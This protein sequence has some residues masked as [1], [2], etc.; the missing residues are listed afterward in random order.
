MRDRIE[1][2]LAGYEAGTITRA[3]FVDQLAALAGG[4]VDRSD[5]GA[6]FQTLGLNHVALS[7]SDVDAMAQFMGAHLGTTVIHSNENA[8]F[9]ACGANHFIG[10]FRTDPL[11]LNHVCFSVEGYDPDDAAV[12]L[13]RAGFSPHRTADRVFFEGPDGIL[14]QVADTWGDYPDP[15]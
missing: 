2:L 15:G 3:E 6:T 8:G 10:L 4:D 1:T 11:G 5:S 9:L 13:E 12:R 7:V 14:F